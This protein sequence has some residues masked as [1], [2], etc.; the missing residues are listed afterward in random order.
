MTTEESN[1]YGTERFAD[2]YDVDELL[3]EGGM[4]RVFL[5]RDTLL[6]GAQV[7]LKVLRR[8]FS[9]DEKHAARFLREIQTTRQVSH[10]NVVRTYEAGRAGAVLFFTMEY[11]EGD[12]LKEELERNGTLSA[13]QVESVLL[14]VCAGLDAIHAA[15]VIHRDL[16]PSNVILSEKGAKIADFGVARP[17]TSELTAHH[18]VIGSAEYMA[19]EQWRGAEIGAAADIYALGVVLYE[20]LV[21]EVP[22]RGET[23]AE[24]MCQHI[25][26]QPVSPA[27]CNAEVPLW[28]SALVMK[29]LSKAPES[30]PQSGA[31]IRDLVQRRSR[32]S[33]SI[34]EP[35]PSRSE[36]GIRSDSYKSEGLSD[37]L[38]SSVDIPRSAAE[39]VSGRSVSE[40]SIQDASRVKI[41]V[42]RQRVILRQSDNENV[43]DLD[44]KPLRMQA[45]SKV[46]TKSKW[47]LG[48]RVKNPYLRFLVSLSAS[49]CFGYLLFDWL[50]GWR[51][52]STADHDSV[53]ILRHVCGLALVV[54]LVSGVPA[55]VSAYVWRPFAEAF[56]VAMR[57]AFQALLLLGFVFA[58]DFARVWWMLRGLGV[59][60]EP[61]HSFIALFPAGRNTIEALLLLPL[62]TPFQLTQT[63]TLPEY[64]ITNDVL[65]A[66]GS[67]LVLLFLYGCVLVSTVGKRILCVAELRLKNVLQLSLVFVSIYTVLA[68]LVWVALS[69][70]LGAMMP[71]P[72]Q[73][74]FGP[75]PLEFELWQLVSAA[76]GWTLLIALVFVAERPH[77][78]EPQRS[79][80]GDDFSIN[81]F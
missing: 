40:S 64:R 27:A 57:H 24:L 51:W 25:E 46:A 26:A 39:R 53:A 47:R 65:V 31:Q 76:L 35:T 43:Q 37:Q 74:H 54:C 36:V 15:G 69:E 63:I 79:P 20:L 61:G 9:Q 4:G 60:V 23:P 6:S 8:E 52:G 13:A 48:F 72:L 3:G 34:E 30:R 28:L 75:Y 33:V 22:F 56:G 55:F 5:V 62:G 70:K 50:E 14:D 18:E 17:F 58:V 1:Q 19:P 59:P 66:I 80:A 78:V 77:A 68:S 67:N 44:T 49:Y 16:K 12:S 38:G 73:V 2:R 81:N 41:G 11:V 32:S 10:P 42:V 21:G 7:A 29:M 71:K 45:L